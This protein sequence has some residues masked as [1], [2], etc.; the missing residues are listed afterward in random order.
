[1]LRKLV[2]FAVAFLIFCVHVNGQGDPNLVGYWNFDDGT[3][4]DLSGN[5]NNGTFMGNAVLNNNPDTV[6]GGFEYS[7]D[8]NF[9]NSNTD[10]VEIPHSDSLN[11]THEL[12]ILLWIRPDDIENWDGMVC[13]GT[14]KCP[15]SLRFNGDNGLR[16]SVNHL[17]NLYDPADPNYAP[18]A[19]GSGEV[20]ST[21][22]VNSVGDGAGVEW[23]YVGVISDTEK[24]RFIKNFE[25]EIIPVK[26]IFAAWDEPLYLGVH[27]PAGF[28]NSSPN[29]DYF[30]G[31]M[32]EVRIYDRAVS[33]RE[34]IAASGLATKP[35]VPEPVDGAAGIV[36]A[37]LSW[38][39]IEGTDKLYLGT[40]PS[41]LELVYE[42]TDGSYTVTDV[43]IGKKYYWRVDVVTASGLVTG[44]TWTFTTAGNVVGG[45]NPS[46]NADFVDVSGIL[47]SWLP[48]FGANTYDVYLGT[49]P[50]ALELLGQV[51]ETSYVDP[52]RTLVSET[53]HYW[54][55]DTVKDGEVVAGPV[56]SFK[57][58]PVFVVEEALVGWYKF[59]LGEGITAVDWTR[60]GNDGF[61]VGGT[62]WITTGYAGGALEFDGDGDYVQIPR[63]VEDD[64]TIMLW[65]RTEDLTQGATGNMA[66]FRTG[67]SALID[68]DYGSQLEN[69][70]ITF[71][72]G[73]I[74][75]G[76]TMPGVGAAASL[77]SNTKIEDSEWHHV[78]WTRDSTTGEMA[79][80]MDGNFDIS[81]TRTDDAWKGTKNAQDHIK[82]G[83]HDYSD[84]Q[85]F[86][87]GQLDEIKFFTRVLNEAEV[88]D[89]M[90]PD[91]RLAFAPQPILGSILDQEKPVT[92]AWKPGDVATA[93][94][95]YLGTNR[96]DL[97]L[98][99]EAQDANEYS[100]GLL[101]PA[102]YYWQ[103][104]E[105]QPDGAEVK[106][107]VWNF[108]VPEYLV[109]DDFEDYNNFSP[110]RVFQRWIDGVGYSADEFFPVENPG[111]GSGAAIG[112]D[113]WSYD[114]PHYDGDIME[115]AIVHDGGQS[116]P[117]YYDNSSAPFTSEIDRTFAIP[118]DWTRKGIKS[119][120][121]WLRGQP[122]PGSFSF[123]PATQSYT[124]IADGANIGGT[125]DQFQFV[126]KMLSGNG[127]ITAKVESVDPTHDWAKAGVMIRDSLDADSANAFTLVP[128][129]GAQN[130]A[131]F[132][133]RILKGDTTGNNQTP[134]NAIT[135]PHWVKLTRTGNVFI[136]EHSADGVNWEMFVPRTILMGVDVYIGLAYTS[137][138]EGTLAKSVFS[139]VSVAGPI[140]PAGQFTT[141]TDIGIESNL[142][143]P[144][145]VHLEDSAGTSKTVVYPVA[146]A[147]Q[148]TEWQEWNIN[149]E[150]FVGVN[151]PS[152]KK[153]TIGVGDNAQPGSK[154]TLYIDDIRLYPALVEE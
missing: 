100:V 92:L 148:R 53:L 83:L 132:Q 39:R 58:M 94:N 20:Q 122:A 15:W 93:H 117:L 65:L 126:Y 57:T 145:Y 49:T 72:V 31:L 55:V 51:P 108:I 112:H 110:H 78:A 103:I 91:K 88:Q 52:S 86:W 6:F 79:L 128:A 24:V 96:D 32:D 130:R 146:D 125:S 56:W 50:D 19:V 152:I 67:S 109:V 90:R 1:M 37:T 38:G 60:K 13:K 23:T 64:W 59:E 28:S 113:I 87:T 89:E 2:F 8:L 124:L 142:E 62:K 144:L 48:T 16:F 81:D 4:N 26:L 68:G 134:Q 150:D 54:R 76:C 98:V 95:V 105:I 17:F 121:L 71:R 139:N 43:L 136:A 119:L 102:N 22:D 84:N 69:F 138:V 46:D 80:F 101:V 41:A 33:R 82:I 66:R 115:M 147:T 29:I 107:D 111:N 9:N 75:A 44:D 73:E 104:G 47:L 40:D 21:F 137:H 35:F 154:G 61:L 7:L 151:L 97:Q 123:D 63:V 133:Y 141:S 116:A 118:Q 153:I 18:G 10:W 140:T 27:L 5:G 74:V 106:G 11:I 135:L 14:T 85:G 143:E 127:S 25:E 36:S 77:R 42:G 34:V 3:A 45:P 30:N 99:S 120:T 114:S 131:R 70:A 12:T 129:P 149:L